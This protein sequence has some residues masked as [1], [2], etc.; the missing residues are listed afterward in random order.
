MSDAPTCPIHGKT[1]QCPACIGRRGGQA[2]TAKQTR[3]RR[4][5]IAKTP[6]VLRARAP[7]APRA[8]QE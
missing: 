7:R 1:L 8:P 6:N 3:A 5:A 2:K 4:R